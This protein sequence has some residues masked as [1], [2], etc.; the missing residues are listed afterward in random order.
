MTTSE[1]S[2]CDR[3][4]LWALAVG[5]LADEEVLDQREHLTTCADCRRR[6]AV[7]RGDLDALGSEAEREMS[8]EEMARSILQR[9]RAIQSRGRRLRWLAMGIVVV[10]AVVCAVALAHRFSE[11]ALARRD[12]WRLEHAI[13]QVQNAE[14]RY[15]ADEAALGRALQRLGDS[16]VRLDAEGRPLDHWGNRIRYRYPGQHVPNG[17]DLWSLGW[18]GEDDQGGPGDLTNWR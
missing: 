8:S 2:A 7:I 17:F 11:N 9:S 18:N 6:F 13:Q 3:D 12:L 5:A 4:R 14:G 15:P 1:G 10:G 16:E